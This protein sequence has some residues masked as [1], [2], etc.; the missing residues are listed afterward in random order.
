MKSGALLSANEVYRYWLW[1][2]WGAGTRRVLFIMLNP[3]TADA[4]RNDPT[5]NRCV[6]FAQS[7]GFD[8]LEIVNLYA[9]RTAYPREL[10]AARDPIGPA[11]RVIVKWRIE[12]A[13]L[14]V[15]AW[16]SHG[17]QGSEIMKEWLA[18]REVHALRLSAKGQP[19]HPL[20]VPAKEN[21]KIFQFPY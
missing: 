21:L 20:Y 14:I 5:V 18:G 3:S 11:N 13:S 6:S 8:G 19:W 10:H 9:L 16:G 7:W 1:R 2:H 12:R 4:S 17:A 15:A